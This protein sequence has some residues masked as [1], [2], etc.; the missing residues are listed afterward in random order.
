MKKKIKVLVIIP[1]RMASSRLPGKP[2]AKIYGIP[3]IGHCYLRSKQSTLLT[4]CYVATPDLEIK[5]YLKSINGHFVM[6]SHKHK[7]CHDRVVE[8]VKKIEKNKK[9]K[10]DIIVNIQ[11]DLP[12][13]FP[14][15]IDQVVLPL[16]KSK[17][18][19]T[20]TMKDQIFNNKDF[21]DH[22][23]V[24]VITDIH[25]NLILTSREPIPS[26]KKY[27]KKFKKYKHVALR[28]YKRK[29]FSEISRLKMTPIEKIE[30][31]DEL[32]LIENGIKIKTVLTK[33][34]T[35]TV[36]TIQDLK[37]VIRMMR[38]DKLRKK[39]FSTHLSH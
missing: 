37:K 5:N 38:D 24:K 8:A 1:A 19:K 2:L 25:N 10:Y 9:I 22:N 16:I 39:Y 23:R 34:I 6:T 20:T 36:D 28:A 29:T 4:D 11:G 17:D 32:R 15:M 13:V 31:I 18:V 26:I 21:F 14:D 35:E 33:K 7:M 3:M 30:A 12:M 27:N